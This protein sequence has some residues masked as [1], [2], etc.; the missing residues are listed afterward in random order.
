MYEDE[1]I[2]PQNNTLT[3]QCCNSM[4]IIN[5]NN[6]FVYISCGQ[7]KEYE[8]IYEPIDFYRDLYRLN[9]KSRY[10]RKYYVMYFIQLFMKTINNLNTMK[11]KSFFYFFKLVEAKFKEIYPNSC[12]FIKLKFIF[13]KILQYMNIEYY[14]TFKTKLTKK[15]LNKY[16]QIWK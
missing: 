8:Y 13:F 6:T 4:R 15:I 3:P 14:Y 11:L 5:D 10:R 1:N 16:N 12:R 7:I 2:I 9:R